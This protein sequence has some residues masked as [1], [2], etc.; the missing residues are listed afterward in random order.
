MSSFLSGNLGTGVIGTVSSDGVFCG[1]GLVFFF[2]L[3][4]D[5]VTQ[6]LLLFFFFDFFFVVV[7]VAAGVLKLFPTLL[8]EICGVDAVAM[9]ISGVCCWSSAKEER[10]FCFL[11]GG[12][13]SSSSSSMSSS[14]VSSILGV[15]F[16]VSF[17][18]VVWWSDSEGDS[19]V[20][21]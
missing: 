7:V 2:P 20:V 8:L 21:V 12:S 14:S 19:E 9:G 11:G 10:C 5:L 18:V 13:S 1:F 6:T 16:S 3:R 15:G 17:E 4:V